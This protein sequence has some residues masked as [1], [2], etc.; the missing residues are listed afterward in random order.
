MNYDNWKLQSAPYNPCE[1]YA[2]YTITGIPSDVTFDTL[3]DA[4]EHLFFLSE[5]EN[6]DTSKMDIKLNYLPKH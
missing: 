3:E 2:Q 6:V 4:T 5:Y 1:Y